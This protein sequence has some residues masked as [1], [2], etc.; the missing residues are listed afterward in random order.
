M[1]DGYPLSLT[2]DIQPVDPPNRDTKQR[3]QLLFVPS[4]ANPAHLERVLI[5]RDRSLI[6]EKVS[7][8]ARTALTACGLLRM[9][10]SIYKPFSGKAFGLTVECFSLLN[11]WKFSTSSLFSFVVCTTTYP[12]GNLSGLLATALMYILVQK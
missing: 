7:I 8:I 3:L 12:T 5:L 4:I 9:V 10:A 11:R 1:P 2:Q 6:L